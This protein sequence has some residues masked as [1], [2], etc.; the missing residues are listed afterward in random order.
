MNRWEQ[1]VLFEAVFG[2]PRRHRFSLPALFVLVFI[3]VSVVRGERHWG[4]FVFAFV[5]ATYLLIQVL[6]ERHTDRQ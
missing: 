4:W 1:W 3:V 2:P 5:C 6:P